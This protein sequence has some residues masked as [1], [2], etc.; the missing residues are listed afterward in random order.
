MNRKQQLHTIPAQS[1]IRKQ[2]NGRFPVSPAELITVYLHTR[3]KLAQ[4]NKQLS[5]QPTAPLFQLLDG[6]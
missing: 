1:E 3:I 4:T 5:S 6:Q 2:A